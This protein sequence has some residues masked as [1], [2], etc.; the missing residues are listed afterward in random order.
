MRGTLIF[1]KSR[2]A[3]GHA[4][5]APAREVGVP[6]GLTSSDISNSS[7]VNWNSKFPSAWTQKARPSGSRGPC[8]R[9]IIPTKHST[10]RCYVKVGSY[11]KGTASR[12]RSDLD[13]LFVLPW[14]VYERIEA[15]TG[16]KQSQFLQEVRRTLLGTFPNTEIAADGQA[17]IAPF[18]TYNVDIVPAFRFISGDFTGQYLIADT[19]DGGRWRSPILSPSTTGCSRR[20]R[21]RRGRRRI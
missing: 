12:P 16:N 15:L 20:M 21:R 1:C 3:R 18:Q 17:V 8:S 19:T 7:S 11:G 5:S 9:S 2:R 10:R 14:E 6:C 13:M 4:T